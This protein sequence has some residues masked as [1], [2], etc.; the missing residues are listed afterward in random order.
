MNDH[1]AEQ[2]TRLDVHALVMPVDVARPQ[3]RS[4]ARI[5]FGGDVARD[6]SGDVGDRNVN[7]CVG[8]HVGRLGDVGARIRRGVNNGCVGRHVGRDVCGRVIG[9]RG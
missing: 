2:S 1:T 9:G 7:G 4:A 8:R 6:I 3:V 5:G